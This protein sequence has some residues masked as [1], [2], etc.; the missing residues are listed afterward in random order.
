MPFVMTDEHELKFNEFFINK[1]YP[2]FTTEEDLFIVLT[3]QSHIFLC[4]GINGEKLTAF[5]LMN[6]N[7]I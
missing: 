2:I 1:I 5:S 6:L 3:N 7:P 4:N